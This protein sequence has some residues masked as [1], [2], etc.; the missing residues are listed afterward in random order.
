L[1]AERVA[2]WREMTRRVTAEIE[3]ALE[4]LGEARDSGN[5]ADGIASFQ[6]VLDRFRD[7]G[8]LLVLPMQSVKLNDIVRAV[9]R[10]LEPLFNPAVSDV[11]RPPVSPEIALAE[12]LPAIRADSSALS[13]ALDTLLLYAVYSMSAGGTFSLR[14]E[15]APGFV[16]LRIEW[17]AAFPNVEEA[18]RMFSS[19]PVKRNY[20]A[21]LE[22]A[23]AQAIISDHDG[24]VETIQGDSTSALIVRLPEEQAAPAASAPERE[25]AAVPGHAPASPLT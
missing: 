18:A 7:F 16:V 22:L 24:T 9:L 19:A 21:G 1:Q 15:R 14:T 23:I 10:D 2:A 4:A 8:E 13:R 12:D 6:R 5:V 3:A 17:P 11:S 20:A 25:P